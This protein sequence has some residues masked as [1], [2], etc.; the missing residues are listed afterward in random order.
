V[1]GMNV[2]RGACQNA[3]ATFSL[4]LWFFIFHRQSFCAIAFLVQPVRQPVRLDAVVM[5]SFPC[6]VRFG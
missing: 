3:D 4:M 1:H 6:L 2:L 5:G